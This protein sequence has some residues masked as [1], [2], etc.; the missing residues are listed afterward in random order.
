MTTAMPGGWTT[1]STNISAQAS[2]VFVTATKGLLGVTYTPLAV[3]TQ[4]V[5]GTNYMFF[6]NAQVVYP[7]APNEA[8]LMTIFSPLQG[9]PV[10]KDITRLL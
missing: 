10:I 3:A 6:C 8:V 1:F 5:A 4:V 9:D 7:N 2:E